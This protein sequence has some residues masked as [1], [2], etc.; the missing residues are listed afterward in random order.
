MVEIYWADAHCGNSGWLTLDEYED[1]GEVIV[2]T[3]GYLIPVGDPGS[4]DKHVTL[5]Q[6]ICDGDGIHPFHIPVDMVRQMKLLHSPHD[7]KGLTNVFGCDTFDGGGQH[8]NTN[9]QTQTWK[10]RMVNPQVEG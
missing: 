10:S 1:D 6:S 8:E 3:C 4:K 7:G 2:R 9:N 5:W